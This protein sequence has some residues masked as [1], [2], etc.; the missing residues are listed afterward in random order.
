QRVVL[1]IIDAG[2]DQAFSSLW[3]SMIEAAD[4]Y[5]LVY[6][7]GD[8]ASF[9]KVWGFFRLIVE[10]KC[11]IPKEVPMLLV[12]SMVDTVGEHREVSLEMGNQLAGTLGIPFRETTAKALRSVEH[13]FRTVI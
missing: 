10:T 2:G 5:M 7:V 4:A 11:Q 9:E 3:P 13:C 1:N 8:K 12:G 6:D